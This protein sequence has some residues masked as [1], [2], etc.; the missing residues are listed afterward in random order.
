M[1][2][3]WVKSA[4]YVVADAQDG[5]G[6]GRGNEVGIVVVPLEGLFPGEGFFEEK[7]EVVLAIEFE[8]FRDR[9]FGDL[10]DGGEPIDGSSRCGDDSVRLNFGGPMDEPRSMNGAV[11][12]TVFMTTVGS[13]SAVVSV[14]LSGSE[15]GRAMIG[16]EENGG[17][18]FEAELLESAMNVA[19]LQVHICDSSEV[20]GFVFFLGGFA[21]VFLSDFFG[22]I[23]IPVR[24]VEVNELDEGFLGVAFFSE[25]VDGFGA[26]DVGGEAGL[27]AFV[28][29]VTN[30]ARFVANLGVVVG[31]KPV[32][33]AVV[34][35]AWNVVI[36]CFL[37]GNLDVNQGAVPLA[38]DGGLVA[39]FAEELRDGDFGF[40]KVNEVA[41]TPSDETV[42][43]LPV[44]HSPRHGCG[45]GGGADLSGGIEV[46]EGGSAV[47]EMV[48]VGS[49]D[50]RVAG[51]SKVTVAEI[52]GYD[53]ND[54]GFFGSAEEEGRE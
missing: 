4:D 53:D 26:D 38:D 42:D 23:D 51:E 49:L 3:E 45:T 10:A 41:G 54:V 29:P 9:S 32:V 50:L 19:H 8:I 5:V 40:W 27:G 36:P 24:F 35:H 34:I 7:S 12:K 52:V 25:P 22:G 17:I 21:E 48:E 20:D 18:F 28:F 37:A 30:P 46:S 11:P 16:G 47:G 2:F 39:V 1:G 6:I 43:A 33:E 13:G 44:W 15:G 14:F 31:A